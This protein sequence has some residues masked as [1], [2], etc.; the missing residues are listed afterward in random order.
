MAT[1]PSRKRQRDVREERG[2]ARRA[3][4]AP[5]L[6]KYKDATVNE[7]VSLCAY[8]FSTVPFGAAGACPCP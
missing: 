6:E 1:E 2:E 7:A 8:A 3:R 5:T 4:Y